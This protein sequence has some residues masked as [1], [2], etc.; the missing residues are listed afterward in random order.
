M[1][2]KNIIAWG[3][4][5]PVI[6]VLLVLGIY[7]L[8]YSLW[9]SL[10]SYSL[11]EPM[12][13][14]RYVGLRNFTNLF[15]R[16]GIIGISLSNSLYLTVLFVTACLILEIGI[17]L[18]LAMIVSSCSRRNLSVVRTLFMMPMLLA[19]VVVGNIFKYL[20]QYSFGLFNF[21][22]KSLRLPTPH[23]LSNPF[24]S[25]I[26]LIIADVWE[27]TPFSFL[28]LL[29]A[30]FSIPEEQFEA[31]YVDGAG[32]S[33]LFLHITLPGIKSAILI[34]LLIR[35]IELIKTFDLVYIVTYGGPGTATA[36]LPFN[37][38]LL[39]FKYFEIGEAAAYAYFMLVIINLFVL[40]F[41]GVLRREVKIE[42]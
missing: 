5:L 11:L 28:V 36:I 37:A 8:I 29:A 20:Y 32:G 22:L 21:I 42:R 4:V 25:L 7:P 23:W 27:W 16:P 39:S 12:R 40:L 18:G 41:I 19:P 6:L 33:Q 35:G 13:G 9:L 17:G 24:W 3:M 34:I 1:S 30:I 38:Y 15:I 2:H 31:A 10:H 14:I 26:S